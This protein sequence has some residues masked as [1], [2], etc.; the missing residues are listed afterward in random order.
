MAGIIA[1]DF[2]ADAG[3][4]GLYDLARAKA[5]ALSRKISA[6]DLT[7]DNLREL[8]SCSQLVIECASSLYSWDIAKASLCQGRDILIMS[9]GGVIDRF[10]GLLRL[11]RRYR[12]RVYIPSGAICGVDALKAARL[13]AIKSVTLTTRKHPLSFKGVKYVLQKR[14]DLGRIS[15]ER[16][17]F[18]GTAKAA[19]RYFP[20]NINVAA[21]LSLAGIGQDKTRVRIIADSSTRRNIHEV[22]VES[23]SG[24]IIARTENV[25]HPDNPKTSYL[26][27]SA[28]AATLKQIFDPV[29]IGT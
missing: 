16:V 17:L 12:A 25:L 4:S 1:R 24:R 9:V 13:S 3:I 28:A 5:E 15:G 14:I 23:D 18:S 6:K 2:S 26:A 29:R 7:K 10:E 19:V 22:S 20:Q 21:L 11:A 27:V 8:V